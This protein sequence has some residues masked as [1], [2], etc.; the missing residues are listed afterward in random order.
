VL[1]EEVLDAGLGHPAEQ[2]GVGDVEG[3]GEGGVVV[4]AGGDGAEEFFFFGGEGDHL[5]GSRARRPLR[6]THPNHSPPRRT[7]GLGEGPQRGMG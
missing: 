2:G 3:F 6:R 4:G 5:S 1:V 7:F